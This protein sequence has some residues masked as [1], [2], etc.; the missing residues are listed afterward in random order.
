MAYDSTKYAGK[1]R[2]MFYTGADGTQYVLDMTGSDGYRSDNWFRRGNS[3][4]VDAVVQ[5]YLEFGRRPTKN[6]LNKYAGL[7]LGDK[8]Y[9]HAVGDLNTFIAKNG[10]NISTYSDAVKK[11]LEQG[12]YTD[13][14][15]APLDEEQQ[16]ELDTSF[17]EWYN[18]MYNLE[19][20]DSFAREM[21]DMY[22]AAEQNAAISNMQLAEAQYQQ[23]AMQQAELIKSI[24]D[25]V[26]SERMAR[27]RAGMSESQI[28]NQDMQLLLSNTNVLNN[29]LGQLNSNQLAA[30]QQYQLAQDTAYQ[31][32]INSL[33]NLGTASAAFSASG[34]GNPDYIAKQYAKNVGKLYKAEEYD[35]VIQDGN[36]INK[37]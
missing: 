23:A 12:K 36:Y 16:T 18:D 10:I 31:Q 20:P 4:N 11:Q 6:E 21:Y 32:Y 28:A 5:F 8:Q 3:K 1:D 15:L 7:D 24:T 34:A 14:I 27:L 19:D 37:S 2:I 29:Q 35:K 17:D 26:K 25:Q 9:E 22:T 13:T 33:Y 30:Q